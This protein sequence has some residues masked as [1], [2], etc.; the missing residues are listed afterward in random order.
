MGGGGCRG[1]W[2]TKRG[3]TGQEGGR[4]V[5]LTYLC[6]VLHATPVPGA[7]GTNP[8]CACHA[9]W[10]EA[11]RCMPTLCAFCTGA[12]VCGNPRRC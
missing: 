7:A 9:G 1:G 12:I 2:G 10:I 11:A 8:L 5:A 3:P 4:G 6:R